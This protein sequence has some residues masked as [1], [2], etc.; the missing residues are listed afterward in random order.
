[1]ANKNGLLLGQPKH[2]AH[3]RN[4]YSFSNIHE[5][6]RICQSG[7]FEEIRNNEICLYACRCV[8]P[9]LLCRFSIKIMYSKNH[10][11]FIALLPRLATCIIAKF[12]NTSPNNDVL[13]AATK[14]QRES[15]F[16]YLSIYIDVVLQWHFI[17]NATF[18][19]W[20][21]TLEDVDC[22]LS[23]ILL[24]HYCVSV[25]C[26][27][28]VMASNMKPFGWMISSTSLHRARV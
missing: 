9:S 11:Y 1:M 27:Q 22:K 18:C 6:D 23:D 13:P 4:L 5:N 16:T 14:P 26:N 21:N 19:I 3:K 2:H 20:E 12:T 25:I 15:L 7:F 8:C 24:R 10:H 17:P 28:V